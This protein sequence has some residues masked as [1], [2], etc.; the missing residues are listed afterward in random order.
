MAVVAWSSQPFCRDRLTL[1]SRAGLEHVEDGKPDRLL[2]FG[3][4]FEFNVRAVPEIV[5]VCALLRNEPLPA[6]VEHL[7]EGCCDLIADRRK[8]AMA[9][10]SVGDELHEAKRL[11]RS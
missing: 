6:G 3:V 1:R 7:A 11:P 10:P 8:R 9:G 5:Q 4:S 2:Q